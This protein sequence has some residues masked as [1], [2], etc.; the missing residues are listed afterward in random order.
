[1][2]VNV[3]LV[4]LFVVC[5]L[6][7][8]VIGRITGRS[9][10]KSE[11]KKKIDNMSD[12]VASWE[13]SRFN[14]VTINGKQFNSF[15]KPNYYIKRGNIIR[16]DAVNM[17]SVHYPLSFST[18]T[19]SE[20]VG[21]LGYRTR[22]NIKTTEG[23]PTVI[24]HARGFEYMSRLHNNSPIHTGINNDRIELDEFQLY[25]T[26]EE[27]QQALDDWLLEDAE[28]KIQEQIKRIEKIKSDKAT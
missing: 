14:P 22:V 4:L 6:G 18:E 15:N 28:R 23:K 10:I 1:M 8:F 27:A 20:D 19:L 7:S 24:L 25:E 9:K 3:S 2:V 26:P 12:A 11:C 16:I 21:G 17:V 5:V 13:D